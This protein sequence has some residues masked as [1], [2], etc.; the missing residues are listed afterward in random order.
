MV[1]KEPTSNYKRLYIKGEEI[2]RNLGKKVIVFT[3]VDDN[4]ELQTA[5]FS[6]VG[7]AFKWGIEN[8]AK[9]TSMQIMTLAEV[10]KYRKELAEQN[11]L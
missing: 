7:V 5:S 1:T 11:K 3:Y 8:S 6:Y 4:M 9:V 2:P 10:H